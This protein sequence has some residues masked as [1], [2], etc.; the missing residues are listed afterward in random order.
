[1]NKPEGHV[2]RDVEGF[3]WDEGN[4]EK[5]V[6]KHR[7]SSAECEEVFFEM[8]MFVFYDA[9]HSENEKR[10]LVLGKSNRGR[11]LFIVF[12]IR[13]NKVRVISARDMSRRERRSYEEK[14]K[15]DS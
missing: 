8:P 7:V 12:T 11:H 10:Y 5:N 4:V 6:R 2:F 9:V 13:R 14:A 15:E 3:E 1:M